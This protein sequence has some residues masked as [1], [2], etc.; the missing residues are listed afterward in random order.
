MACVVTVPRAL[1]PHRL[2]VA[3]FAAAEGRLAGEWPLRE[4]GRLQQ[5]AL[6]LGDDSPAQGVRWSARGER[7]AVPAGEAEIWLHLHAHTAL[8][9]VCQR[10]LQPVTVTL[11]PRQRLR[12]VRGE[13]KAEQLDED[14]DDDVLALNAMLDLRELIEDELI[15]ALPLVPRHDRCPQALPLTA[16]AAELPEAV[17]LD[18]PFAALAHLRRGRAGKSS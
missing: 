12:F 5:D 10:C 9:L 3:A 2:D 13:D 18:H 8:R 1:D 7:R 6:P 17:P 4:L 16:G 14:S 11:D 15:L